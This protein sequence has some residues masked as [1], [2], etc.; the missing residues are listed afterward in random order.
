MCDRSE[1][2][3]LYTEHAALTAMTPIA[4]L[5]S[6]E[7]RTREHD[8]RAIA[9]N[10][11][12]NYEYWLERSDPLLNTILPGTQVSL[13][14]NFGD[15]W[16]TGRC[17]PSSA[18]MPRACV[19]GPFTQSR[20]LRVG[21]CVRAVGAVISPMLTHAVFDVPASQLVDR[22]VPLQDLWTRREVETLLDSLSGLDL[23]RCVSAVKNELLARIDR[24]NREDG[25]ARTAARMIRLQAGRVSI[26]EIARHHSLS[27][28]EFAR[29]FCAGAGLRPKLFARITRFQSLVRTLLSTDVSQWASV[30]PAIGFYDQSHMIN[31]FRTFAGSPPTIFFRP[32]DTDIDPANIQLRGRPSEWVRQSRGY[33]VF[34]SDVARR[35]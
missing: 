25:V 11:A 4:S 15:M 7:T 27:R 22:V 8:R 31:E 19:A 24:P 20:I 23:P 6:Y 10:S 5:W 13:I 3:I 18:F 33:R 9:L 12:G 17:L 29:R 14:I 1:T 28:Q 21:R 35:L 34:R 30:S 16:A 26:D 32:H 2:G